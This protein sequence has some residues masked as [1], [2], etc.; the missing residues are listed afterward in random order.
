MTTIGILILLS[1]GCILIPMLLQ[2][3]F[4]LSGKIAWTWRDYL[5]WFAGAVTWPLLALLAWRPKSLSNFVE[6][7]L[8]QLVL[9]AVVLVMIRARLR[10]RPS[11]P[12][13]STV[14]VVVVSIAFYAGM[15]VLAE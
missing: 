6:A 9:L 4:H 8:I 3:G 1:L 11:D 10:G 13:L 7:L 15:P 14:V 12:W 5:P 2:V